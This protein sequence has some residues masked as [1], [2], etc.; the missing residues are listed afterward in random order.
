M[1]GDR[2]E[3]HKQAKKRTWPTEYPAILTEQAW[4]KIRICVTLTNIQQW[5]KLLIGTQCHTIDFELS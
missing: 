1:D 4:S 2:V 3:V 5:D